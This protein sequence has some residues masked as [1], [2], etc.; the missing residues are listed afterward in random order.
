MPALA[1]REG[2][3]GRGLLFDTLVSIRYLVC[4]FPGADYITACVDKH[5]E[6]ERVETEQNA[7]RAE[8]SSGDAEKGLA[9]RNGRWGW[10]AQSGDFLACSAPFSFSLSSSTLPAL[11]ASR[12]CRQGPRGNALWQKRCGFWT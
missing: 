2:G 7:K 10:G 3:A 12:A 1:G 6:L 8:V 4:I 9:V 11:V 5:L